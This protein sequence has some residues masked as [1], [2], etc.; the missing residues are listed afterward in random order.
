MQCY[1]GSRFDWTRSIKQHNAA[2]ASR[3][4]LHS[5]SRMFPTDH[6]E[7]LLC[8]KSISNRKML[9]LALANIQITELCSSCWCSHHFSSQGKQQNKTEQVRQEERREISTQLLSQSAFKYCSTSHNRGKIVYNRTMY[10]GT[11]RFILKLL[12]PA[13]IRK[14]AVEIPTYPLVTAEL[15]GVNH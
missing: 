2:E 11:K 9:F 15:V 7:W 4:E 10:C 1:N 5:S 14:Q 12:N 6:E 8:T 3:R 13:F